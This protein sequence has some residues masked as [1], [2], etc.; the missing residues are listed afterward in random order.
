MPAVRLALTVIALSIAACAPSDDGKRCS[1]ANTDFKSDPLNCGTCGNACGEDA[2]C[3]DSKCQVGLCQ[4]GTIESCYTGAEDTQDVGPCVAGTRTCSKSGVWSRCE[5]EVVPIAENC[6]DGLDNNCNGMTDEDIDLDH[7]GFN[8]CGTATRPPDCCDSTECGKPAEVNPGAFDPTDGIDN[9]C[10]GVV[11]DTPLYCDTE[12]NSNSTNPRDFAKA[13]DF[14]RPPGEPE[15]SM[16][17]YRWG[18][19]DAQLTLTDGTRVPDKESYAIRQRF[20]L[21]LIPQGGL[22]FAVISSGGAAAKTE[23]ASKPPLYHDWSGYSTPLSSN[24]P[25]D[26]YA[27]NLNKLPN[28]PGCPAPNSTMANDPVMLRLQ[29]RVP[30]NAKSFKFSVNFFTAEFPEWACSAYNDFFVV[31]LDSNYNLQNPNGPNLNPTDKN[32]AFFQPSG[33]T[34]KYPV[35]V[36]L[37][38]GNTGLFTQCMPGMVACSGNVAGQG[39]ITTCVSTAQLAGTG[40]DDPQSGSCDTNSLKG[41][42]TGWLVTAGNVV[43]GEIITLRVAIWDTSDHILDSVALLDAFTWSTEPV[44]PGTVIN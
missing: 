43:P 33:S 35:G 16:E 10:N 25:S 14:C 5:N 40:L 23:D 7:D 28:A 32:L 15:V 19:I 39:Q 12:L 11:D 18:V 36:N 41:G 42:G 13:L 21:G 34:A 31:L 24:F 38:T 4:P 29:V 6:S 30:T 2:A 8:T 1:A 3:I 26:W 37:A 9:D 20:G 22:S 27:L 17:D 44:N